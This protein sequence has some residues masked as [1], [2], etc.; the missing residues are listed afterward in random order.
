[1]TPENRLGMKSLLEKNDLSELKLHPYFADIDFEA[2][3]SRSLQIPFTD[4]ALISSNNTESDEASQIF[5]SP[6]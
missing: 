4:N 3:A 5:K 1:M 6:E 2:L